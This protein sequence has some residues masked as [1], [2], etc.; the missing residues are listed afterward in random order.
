MIMA[1]IGHSEQQTKARYNDHSWAE[2]GIRMTSKFPISNSEY[3]LPCS[4][5][6]G[7]LRSVSEQQ[8]YLKTGH[9]S[10]SLSLSLEDLAAIVCPA[11]ARTTLPS[12][13]A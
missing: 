2:I 7:W 3:C 10:I 8:A 6:C 11:A 5:F 9:Y 12:N 4:G 13:R 1:Y